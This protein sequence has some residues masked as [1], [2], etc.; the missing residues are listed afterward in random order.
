MTFD[1]AITREQVDEAGGFV[2]LVV[3]AREKHGRG[4]AT[5]EVESTWRRRA[6]TP[7]SPSSRISA[8]GSGRAGGAK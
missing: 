7:A 2:R 1:A 4:G 5:A 8:A 3:S 6:R